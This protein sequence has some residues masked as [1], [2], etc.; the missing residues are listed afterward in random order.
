MVRVNFRRRRIVLADLR[1]GF[2]IAAQVIWDK[3]LFA[4]GRF[5]VGRSQTEP[6]SRCSVTDQPFPMGSDGHS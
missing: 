3:G 1:I 4:M 2:E 5:L 6:S